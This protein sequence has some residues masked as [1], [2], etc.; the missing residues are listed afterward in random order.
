MRVSARLELLVVAGLVIAAVAVRLPTLGQPLLEAG[1]GFRQ[2]QTAYTA[3]LYREEGISLTHPKLPVLGE[4]FEVPYEFPA[5]QALARAVMGLG[6]GADQAM[7]VTSLAC[8]IATALLLFGFVRRFAGRLAASATLAIFLFSPFS[9]LWSR[10]SLME[11]LA[12]AAAVAYVW[13]AIE[14]RDSRR[15]ILA[16]TAMLAGCLAFLVKVTTGVVFLVPILAYVARSDRP[17]LRGAVRARLDPVLLAIVAVPVVAGLLWTRHADRIK[18][19]SPL[20]AFL[21]SEALSAW[22]FGTL[23]QRLDLS[24][25]FDVAYRVGVHQLGV[26]LIPLLVL[27]ALFGARRSLWLGWAGAG[28]AAVA[29]F[30]NLHVVHDYYQV[31]VAPA[32]AILAGVG[33]TALLRSRLG[34]RHR[35]PVAAAA[36]LGVLIGGALLVDAPYWRQAFTEIPASDS[37]LV[38]ADAIRAHSSPS[39]LVAVVGYDWSPEVLYYARRK[40]TMFSSGVTDSVT[41]ETLD[42]SYRLLVITSRVPAERRGRILAHWRVARPVEPGVYRV[43][44]AR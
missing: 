43:S 8:F 39:E 28:V 34:S 9:L 14:W 17:G 44:G 41:L 25:W 1:H 5:F 35:S 36:V 15:P 31:A 32:T 27:G 24:N 2:T 11:Y 38:V 22:N 16:V 20:T 6:L 4:P 3:V 23:E 30:F 21:T 33:F 12:T 26:V 10:A 19:E 29:T 7:R 42:E 18:G 37:R 13:A 40:G